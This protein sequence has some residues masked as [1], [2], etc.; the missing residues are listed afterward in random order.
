MGKGS[1][2]KITQLHYTK[3]TPKTLGAQWY[4][5]LHKKSL[6]SFLNR[7]LNSIF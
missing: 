6:K 5:L 3:I 7:I 1:N 2:L 4:Y